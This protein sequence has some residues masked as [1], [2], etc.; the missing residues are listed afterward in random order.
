MNRLQKGDRWKRTKMMEG[1]RIRMKRK[2][3]WQ[4]KDAIGNEKKGK[5]RD[6]QWE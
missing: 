3:E 6:G 5:G 1:K 4:G 2:K